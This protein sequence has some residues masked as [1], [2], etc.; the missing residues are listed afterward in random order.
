MNNYTVKTFHE[1]RMSP[2]SANY[3]GSARL[4]WLDCPQL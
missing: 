4:V 1:L 3:L 2:R